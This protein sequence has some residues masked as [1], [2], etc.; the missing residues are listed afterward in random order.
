MRG[1]GTSTNTIQKTFNQ[2]KVVLMTNYRH[3]RYDIDNYVRHVDKTLLVDKSTTIMFV[4]I[5]LARNGNL[6]CANENL[7]YAKCHF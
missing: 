7:R 1:I 4:F 5:D 3:C 2:C 6:G